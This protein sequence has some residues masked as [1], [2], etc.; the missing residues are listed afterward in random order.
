M[1][2]NPA[3]NVGKEKGGKVVTGRWAAA[4]WCV[5]WQMVGV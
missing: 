2:Q 1:K 5:V 4:A 3:Q